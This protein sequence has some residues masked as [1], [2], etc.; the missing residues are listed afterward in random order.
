MSRDSLAATMTA[1]NVP[2]T[3]SR[4]SHTY[5]RF[6]RSGGDSLDNVLACAVLGPARYE[7]AGLL[8]SRCG[9][10]HLQ[11]YRQGLWKHS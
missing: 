11:S 4:G 1:T 2:A 9:S 7:L 5:R 8:L 3:V 10:Q 6:S